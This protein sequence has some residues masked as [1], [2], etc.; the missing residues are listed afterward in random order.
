MGQPGARGQS[1]TSLSRTPLST[2]ETHGQTE[3]NQAI[4]L[5]E[6]GPNHRRKEPTGNVLWL[7]FTVA[8]AFF[9]FFLFPFFPFSSQDEAYQSKLRKHGTYA[10]LLMSVCRR[11]PLT[12]KRILAKAEPFAS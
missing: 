3:P 7:R 1:L 2:P 12:L 9:F 5:T 11:F 4:S 6:M 10:V 8:L